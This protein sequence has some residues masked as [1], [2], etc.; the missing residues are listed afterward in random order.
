[1]TVGKQ[2]LQWVPSGM[3]DIVNGAGDGSGELAEC[4]EVRRQGQ[5]GDVSTGSSLS[6]G[7]FKKTRP[8]AFN[9][10]ATDKTQCDAVQLQPTNKV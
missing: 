8:A 10:K 1:M 5:L 2:T 7:G 9:S 4:R 3:R 6:P